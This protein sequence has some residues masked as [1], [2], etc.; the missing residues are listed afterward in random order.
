MKINFKTKE[1][2]KQFIE[3]Y[4]KSFGYESLEGW[5]KDPDIKGSYRIF[6]HPN[7]KVMHYNRVRL[8]DLEIYT[9]EMGALSVFSDLDTIKDFLSKENLNIPL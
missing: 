7:E 2:H 8:S 5:Y 9:A 6:R 4:L 3:D 1:N